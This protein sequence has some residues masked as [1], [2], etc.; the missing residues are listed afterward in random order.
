MFYG[1]FTPNIPAGYG[2]YDSVSECA[3]RE[4]M[5]YMKIKTEEM[6]VFYISNS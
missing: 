4:Q 5:I 2:P 1:L 6:R 3:K